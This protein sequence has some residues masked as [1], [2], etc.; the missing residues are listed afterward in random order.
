[1]C[2]TNQWITLEIKELKKGRNVIIESNFYHKSQ[3]E[4][5]QQKIHNLSF[6]FTLKADLKEL[7][8]RDNLRDKKSK[9]GKK[10]INVVYDLTE[11]FNH[12]IVINTDNQN[13]KETINKIISHLPTTLKI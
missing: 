7:I 2:N 5:L 1:M 8:S 11:K 10:R 4:D 9:I 12:G 13:V 6:V 3:I